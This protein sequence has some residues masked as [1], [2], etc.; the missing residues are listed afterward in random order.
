MIGVSGGLG[1]APE[2]KVGGGKAQR[3]CA[4]PESPSR[5]RKHS[6]KREFQQK[7]EQLPLRYKDEWGTVEVTGLGEIEDQTRYLV[8]GTGAFTR[9]LRMH[10]AR[11][12]GLSNT[13]VSL[14]FV[15]ENRVYQMKK[16]NSNSQRCSR[17]PET[18]LPGPFR[19]R[20]YQR[21]HAIARSAGR[22]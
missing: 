6:R 9:R 20:Q 17:L 22:L 7:C 15:P 8:H 18:T 5:R 14:W 13:F 16:L 2:K 12:S 4:G 19:R 1:V 3:C 11:C 21:R 10:E